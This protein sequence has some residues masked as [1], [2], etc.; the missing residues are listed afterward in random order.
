[1]GY[2]KE[3]PPTHVLVAA[4]LMGGKKGRSSKR[5]H[6]LNHGDAKGDV[7]TE[8]HDLVHQVALAGGATNRQLPDIYRK[9]KN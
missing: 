4:Y 1:M 5:R 2:W 9:E 7:E 8:F 6:D 3:H